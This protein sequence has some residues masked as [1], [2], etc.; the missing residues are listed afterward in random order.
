SSSDQQTELGDISYQ[1]EHD[2]DSQEIP[3]K[4]AEYGLNLHLSYLNTYKQSSSHRRCN[5]SDAKIEDHHNNKVDG[6][7]SQGCAYRQENRCKDQAG[8]CHVHKSTYD[9]Q[10]DIDNKQDHKFIV[11]DSQQALRNQ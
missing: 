3:E 2:K 10:D 5:G 1:H 7:H 4:L 8:R 11:A 9:Q 6:V